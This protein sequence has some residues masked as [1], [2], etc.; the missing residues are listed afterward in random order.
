LGSASQFRGLLHFPAFLSSA[1]KWDT[2]KIGGVG[3]ADGIPG[4]LTAQTTPEERVEIA[5][6]TRE[7]IPKGNSWSDGYYREALGSL[8]L[9]LEA[10][11]LDDE[12]F[13]KIC[14]DTGRL[15]DLIE[16]LIII[17]L[18]AICG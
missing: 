13:L 17:N 16:R 15:N 6:W 18:N 2:I 5:K 14:R 3:A 7:I 1:Y 12:A 9:D 10:D 11:T 4:I 8:L